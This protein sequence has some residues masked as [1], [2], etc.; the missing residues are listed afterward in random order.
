MASADVDQTALLKQVLNALKV[1]QV[2]QS[3]LASNVDAINGRV[4]I[5]AGIKEV[6]DVASSSTDGASSPPVVA[7]VDKHES[8]DHADVPESPS[9][10]AVEVQRAGTPSSAIALSGNRSS[11]ATTRIILTYA[12]PSL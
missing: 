11:N 6:E 9:E 10:T 5:L 3:Q 2:N 4:N 12:L 8:H 7:A 1:L